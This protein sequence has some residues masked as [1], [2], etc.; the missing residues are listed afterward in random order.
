LD[1][2]CGT[3][4]A[5]AVLRPFVKTLT[6]IDL[7]S[8][9]LAIAQTKMIYD[10][11]IES[12]LLGYLQQKPDDFDC[13][14]AADV[15]PY[16][17][18]L[19]PLWKALVLCLAPKAT[20]WFTTEISHQEPW[21]LQESMRFCHHPE[22]IKTLCAQYDLSVIHIEILAARKQDGQDLWVNF[23]GVSR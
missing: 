15:L 14:V 7:S 19:Q 2:G 3:G 17:G 12:E 5:G 21:K 18:D 8:K 10:E 20:F 4:L 23:F 16:F 1:I 9:M 6:G 11:L 13:I 22:Y